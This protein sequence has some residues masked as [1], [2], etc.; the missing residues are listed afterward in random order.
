M[1]KE[2]FF[3]HHFDLGNSFLF[4]H[5]EVSFLIKFISLLV[6]RRTFSLMFSFES[7]SSRYIFEELGF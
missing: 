3:L 5:E 4:L 2:C 1:V 7:N 6:K